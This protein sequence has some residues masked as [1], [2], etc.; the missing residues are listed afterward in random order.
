MNANNV[1][2]VDDILD[3][4]ADEDDTDTGPEVRC[5][6]G[7][8]MIGEDEGLLYRALRDHPC[9]N[10]PPDEVRQVTGWAALVEGAFSIEGLALIAMVALAVLV[11]LGKA[12]LPWQ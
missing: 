8:E 11:A 5:G 3:S 10:R 1:D 12:Q 6:C 2:P 9:P 4:P 7:F